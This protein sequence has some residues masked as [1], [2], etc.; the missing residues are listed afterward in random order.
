MKTVFIKYNPYRL[1]TDVSVNGKPV[2]KNSKLNITNQRLQEWI[3]ALPEILLEECSTRDFELVFHG[4]YLDFV[5]I[6]AVSNEAK[7]KNINIKPIHKPA[8]EVKDKELALNEIFK[9]IQD[10]PFEALKQEDVISAFNLAKTKEFEVNVVATMSAGKSTLINAL[11]GK[12]LMPA[13]QEACT[14]TITKIHDNDK[15]NF[16]AE[17]F[18]QN[19]KV[20][21]TYSNL[22]YNLMEQLNSSPNVSKIDISGNIPFVTSEESSLVLVD[23]PGPNNA[24]DKEHKVK[25]YNMLSE[26]SKTL[27]LYI[28]NA[29]QL[30]VE[31]DDNLLSHVAESMK[32]GGRQSRDRFIFVINKMDEYWKDEDSVESAIQKV[33]DY[34]SD[35]GIE[36]PNIYPISAITALYIRDS[37]E[38]IKSMESDD[39]GDP[40]IEDA[41]ML[42]RRCIK[43]EKLHFEDYAPLTVKS[44][45]KIKTQLLTYIKR[46]SLKEQAL[47]H[48]GI[49]TLEDTIKSYVLKYSKTAKIKNIVDTFDKKLESER[50]FE[51]AKKTLSMCTEN[52][53]EIK[54]K[55][56]LIEAKLDDAQNMNDF[57]RKINDINYNKQIEDSANKIVSKVEAKITKYLKQTTKDEMSVE[58]AKDVHQKLL[59]KSNDIRA[60]MKSDI[61]LMVNKTVKENA[62]NL[63]NEYKLKLFNLVDEL[64]IL[65]EFRIDPFKLME[66]NINGLEDIEYL[67]E[68]TTDV[69]LVNK[70][71]GEYKEYDEIFGFRRWLNKQMGTDF[72]V[73]FDIVKV[74]AD[75]EEEFVDGKEL[76]N[77]FIVP[78]QE[79]LYRDKNEVIK[80]AKNEVKA[81]KEL[82]VKEFDKLDLLLK[83]K[84]DELKKCTLDEQ[85]ASE[86]LKES[87]KRLKWLEQLDKKLNDILEI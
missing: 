31:D 25:T 80:Y 6:V 64:D 18:D 76:S 65:D 32:I 81:V 26:S 5:D 3:D 44:K 23:T 78:I 33:K 59:N 79:N 58:E 19:G 39:D 82:F 9:E 7:K 69:K 71:I 8:K 42:V 22:T 14:A 2:K 4:T 1:K 87:K 40:E 54:N 74:F 34:L 20:V 24:R 21:N 75:I 48:S 45:D 68:G 12:K 85:L 63:L 49:I 60:K 47:I 66:G 41:K 52:K 86:K 10:G 16:T 67:L 83:E 37:L 51:E 62:A 50:M 36:N 55:I 70:V 77:R 43:K 11:L 29:Q 61:E 27:V 38:N 28:L 15:E 72:K 17:A 73:N 53:K 46:N 13:T 35:K 57:R 30:A 84:L 56:S